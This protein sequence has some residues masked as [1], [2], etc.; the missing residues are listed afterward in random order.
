MALSLRKTWF[1]PL[2]LLIPVALVLSVTTYISGKFKEP[3]PSEIIEMYR[4]NSIPEIVAFK[5]LQGNEARPVLMSGLKDREPRIRALCAECLLF[6]IDDSVA[7]ALLDASHDEVAEVRLK[8]VESLGMRKSG[9]VVDRMCEMLRKDP[10]SE[11]RA[12]CAGKLGH[13]KDTRAGKV[14][15]EALTDA[16]SD[17]QRIA[18]E[19][20]V[21]INDG[22]AVP[23]LIAML[24]DERPSTR[25][26]ACDVLG[27]LK[28]TKALIRIRRLLEDDNGRV[29]SCAAKV[30]EAVKDKE[31]LPLLLAG[32]NDH[33]EMARLNAI[34]AIGKIGHVEAVPVFLLKLEN[35]TDLRERLYL[36]EA[37]GD[38]DSLKAGDALRKVS[39]TSESLFER[40]LAREA[41][42]KL[43]K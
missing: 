2:I 41:M 1:I 12:A 15:V 20:L 9:E 19:A 11:V 37:L 10:D 38:I 7:K 3:S 33:I 29:R 6:H 16:E 27:R 36:I 14:L 32:I 43:N 17:V 34:E 18:A 5:H 40:Q 30:L 23:Y 21:E 8:S 24:D 26:M 35:T 28:S 13:F 4:S 22:N 31:A 42:G 25:A 39:E